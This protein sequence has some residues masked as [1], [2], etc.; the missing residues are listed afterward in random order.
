MSYIPFPAPIADP[1][2]TCDDT[3]RFR[4]G[5]LE[6]SA[7]ARPARA[8]ANAFAYIVTV[9]EPVGVGRNR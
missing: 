1:I 2:F 9:R 6:R 8:G 5:S 3:P 4:T 7:P